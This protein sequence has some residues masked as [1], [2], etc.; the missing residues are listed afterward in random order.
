MYTKHQRNIIQSSNIFFFEFY[1]PIWYQSLNKDKRLL[2]SKW[3]LHH[4]QPSLLLQLSLPFP[5]SHSLLLLSY[6]L[7]ITRYGK[8]KLCLIFVVMIFM[9]ILM[10]Q[11]L[12]HRKKLPSLTLPQVQVKQF[13]ILSITSGFVRIP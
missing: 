12:F 8:L 4:P 9:A 7:L 1:I 10:A 3:L 6:T 11:S 2:F 5:I 13:L